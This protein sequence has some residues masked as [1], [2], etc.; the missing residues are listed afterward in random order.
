[1][2]PFSRVACRSISRSRNLALVQPRGFGGALPEPPRPELRR[3]RD[4]LPRIPGPVRGAR[5]IPAE[6]M[7]RAPRR[8]RGAVHAQLPAVRDRLLR[9][10]ARGRRGRADQLH[11]H[12][13]RARASAARRGRLDHRHGA[14]AAA[15]RRAVAGGHRPAFHR[16]LLRGLRWRRSGV[17]VARGAGRAAHA[18]LQKK[19]HAGADHALA[20]SARAGARA[21]AA[22]RRARRPGVDLLHLRHDGQAQGLH[23]PAPRRHAQR[24][25]RRALARRAPALVHARRAAAVPRHRHAELHERARL[26]R[27]EHGAAAA[28]E[29]RRGVRSHRA[30]QGHQ[31]HHR[32]RDDRGPHHELRPRAPRPFFAARHRRRRRGHARG[33][34]RATQG[35]S[36]ASRISRAMA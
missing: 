3:R 18:H 22:R 10:L 34:G 36:R 17:G 28:L 35:A 7:R 11:E 19:R 16:R 8:P 2:S 13:G 31:P 12:H 32:A 1:M 4:Q 26:R 5:G 21:G 14:G 30:P 23:A 6:G 25:G 27:F 15:A 29:P 9:H 33:R 24:R 20:R